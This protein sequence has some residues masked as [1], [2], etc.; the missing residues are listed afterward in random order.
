M[1]FWLVVADQL[2][3]LVLGLNES[4]IEDHPD[5][6]K[7]VELAERLIEANQVALLRS[8]LVDLAD[9]FCA[10]P[11]AEELFLARL[12]PALLIDL[13]QGAQGADEQALLRLLTLRHLAPQTNVWN[14]PI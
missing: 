3:M 14:D 8:V 2:Q 9:H 7:A 10:S 4:T 1:T 11:P 12:A 6:I 5:V 13:W